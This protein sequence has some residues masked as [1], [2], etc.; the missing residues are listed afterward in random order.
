MKKTNF[1]TNGSIDIWIKERIAHT[2][3]IS[4]ETLELDTPFKQLGLE[5]IHATAI[6]FALS[7]ELGR[8][9]SEV[10]FWRYPTISEMADALMS[11]EDMS[12]AAKF[13]SDFGQKSSNSSESVAII[14]MSCRLPGWGATPLLL[15]GA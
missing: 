10:M 1:T 13:C 3:G 7:R 5:S 14:G 9:L 4:A 11:G 2:L 15:F 12:N 8:P 6:I